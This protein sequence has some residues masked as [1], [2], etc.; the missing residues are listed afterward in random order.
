MAERYYHPD[1]RKDEVA[2]IVGA[3]DQGSSVS[4]IG[5][6]SVGK[7]NLLQFLDQERLT[8]TEPTSPWL[9]YAPNAPQKGRIVAV[10]IDP[11]ALLPALPPHEKGDVAAEAWP[12]FE[13]LTHRTSITPQLYPAISAA[14]NRTLAP[15][16]ARQIER[17]RDRF[18]HAHPDLT[19]FEDHLHAH[20]A[21]RHL[22]NLLD[23]TITAF[24]LQDNPIRIAYFMD[25]FER[26]LDTMPDYFFVALRSL[27]DRF[28]Y[29]VMFVTFTRN[30]LPYL[31]GDGERMTAIE[32][33][34]ELFHD[35]AVYLKPF[36]DDDA[37]RMVEQ[38]EERA[39]SKDDYGLGL[40]IRAS[41]GFAGLLRAGF[42]RAETLAQVQAPDYAQA[43]GL[44]AGRL[45]MEDNVQAECKT[46]LRGLNKEEIA[47]LYGVAAQQTNLNADTL[48]ELVNKSLVKQNTQGGGVRVSPPM[49]AA[50][51]HD[52]PTP[53]DPKPISRPVTMPK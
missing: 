14:Q 11:N 21:L 32:P 29:Q 37:W 46:L 8:A 12:G 44:A 22:E 6:P 25:E 52:H 1:Y 49:L 3:L 20:L 24:R 13:L 51:I 41:G 27:R 5:P 30:S 42:K 38:L 4:V 35:S 9:R 47:T 2:Q 10:S 53:P 31:I 39:V 34:V 33:F 19:D 40:L 43:I 18:D 28:K 45:V 23:T 16:L 15:D 36:G 17:L 7:S 26:L 48:R 50:Y